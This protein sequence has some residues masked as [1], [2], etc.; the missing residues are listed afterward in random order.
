MLAPGE[1]ATAKGCDVGGCDAGGGV[2]S[3][4]SYIS[5]GADMGCYTS[6]KIDA[7]GEMLGLGGFMEHDESSWTLNGRWCS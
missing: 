1:D 4:G 7:F 3:I 5:I 2:T 6:L